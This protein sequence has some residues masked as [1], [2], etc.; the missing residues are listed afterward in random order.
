MSPRRRPAAALLAVLLALPAAGCSSG[1]STERTEQPTAAATLLG[2]FEDSGVT[3]TVALRDWHD[4][5]GTLELSFAPEEAG[6][7]LYA[8]DLPPDGVDGV[9]R[10]TTARTDGALGATAPL[11]VAAPVRRLALEGIAEPVPVYPDGPVTATLPV[12]AA[13]TGPAVV[14]V[15][16]AACSETNG[17]LMP[18]ADHPVPLTVTPA[19]PTAAPSG[20]SPT[21]TPR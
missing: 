15:G 4:G 6:F 17:C 8:V 11:A 12:R 10:P 1:G 5:A 19:G 13:G 18:V 20:S 3:V 9:G 21:A 16:Y 14:H 7:H 2:R